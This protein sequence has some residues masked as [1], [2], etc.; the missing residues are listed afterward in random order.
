VP[1]DLSLHF[2]YYRTDLLD[3]LLADAAW[4]ARYE[5]I[6]EKQ[7]GKKLDPK[8]PDQ[9]T[10]DDWA[11]TALFF[12]K[13]I[14][15]GS[16]T[17]YGTV[18]QMKNLLFNMMVWHSTAR[19]EG[20]DWMDASG[21]ITVNSPAFRTA[22]ELYKKL[23]DAGASSKDS[24][25]YEYAEANAASVPARRRRCCNGVWLSAISTTR[26]RPPWSPARSAQSRRP[27]ARP[28]VSHISTALAS[29][30]TRPRSTRTAH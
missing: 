1:T 15:P 2:M 24:T 12:T 22:L 19:S 16:P 10:W 27:P 5:E 9:W 6:S 17:R 28:G 14:N 20:G 18:L 25:T 30:S 7:L 23:Y 3:K 29:V 26:T 11:A 8:D 4:K 13:A 21:K